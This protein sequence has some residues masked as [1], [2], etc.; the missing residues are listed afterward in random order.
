[1]AEPSQ[2]PSSEGSKATARA[3]ARLQK[4]ASA[5]DSG[6]IKHI[7]RR[8][9][10]LTTLNL[11]MLQSE[12]LKLEADFDAVSV[13]VTDQVQGYT[14]TYQLGMHAEPSNN[15]LEESYKLKFKIWNELRQ[16][17]QAYNGALLEAAQLRNLDIAEAA[18]VEYLRL[19][20]EPQMSGKNV[21][22]AD[23]NCWNDKDDDDLVS[24]QT[25]KEKENKFILG[26]KMFLY[27]LYWKIRKAP[28]AQTN[29]TNS[30]VIPLRT[31]EHHVSRA[32][33]ER[34]KA[35]TSRLFMALFGGIAL[36]V[37]TV[38][39]SKHQGLNYSLITTAIAT[40]LFAL[41]LALGATDSTGKDVLAAT[42]AYAAVLVVFIGTSLAKSPA[43]L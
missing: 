14:A 23:R 28:K 13:P 20:L 5:M 7:F 4:V 6:E 27:I 10:N 16:K 30:N 12:L 18:D 8:F 32:T 35:I 29:P 2:D 31:G 22:E 40:V 19:W 24:L 17:L 26:I 41:M 25:E 37:P 36:I 3:A 39:M 43:S 38:I 34:Q 33:I 42:A 9:G 21:E 15:N 1:M 11:L